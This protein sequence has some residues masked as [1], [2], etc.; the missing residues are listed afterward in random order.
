MFIFE[1][2]RSAKKAVFMSLFINV[3]VSW[4]SSEVSDELVHVDLMIVPVDVPHVYFQVTL[5]WLLRQPLPLMIVHTQD[6][7][8]VLATEEVLVLWVLEG[9]KVSDL[10]DIIWR[11]IHVFALAVLLHISILQVLTSVDPA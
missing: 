4:Y 3:L 11:V 6:Y 1:K 9:V 5:T 7:A 2:L 8:V 10:N